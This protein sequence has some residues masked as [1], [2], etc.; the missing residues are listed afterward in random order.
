MYIYD[1]VLLNS[2]GKVKLLL[3]KLWIKFKN[4]HFIFS[5]PN[6]FLKIVGFTW[7]NMVEPLLYRTCPLHAG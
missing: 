6:V 5:S 7:K 1:N 4:V 2:S 3:K